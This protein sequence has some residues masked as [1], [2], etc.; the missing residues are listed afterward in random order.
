MAASD[1]ID[2]LVVGH[3]T[4]DLVEEG[5]RCGGA[6]LYAS[7]TAD[8][9]GLRAAILTRAASDEDLRDVPT[10][11]TVYRL[12]SRATTEFRNIYEGP[13]RTQQMTAKGA[14]IGP[15]DVPAKVT[16]SRTVL[17]G[18]VIGEIDPVVRSRFSGRVAV[19]AQ[20]WLRT[21]TG[22]NV[23]Y[24]PWRAD[25]ALRGTEAVFA[26]TEDAPASE[27]PALVFRWRGAVPIV[28]VTEGP[29]GGTLYLTDSETAIPR[30]PAREVDPTG[31]GD[32]FAAAFLAR[33]V[34][35]SDPY[36]AAEF[37]AAAAACS[38]EGTGIS[39]IPD[40]DMIAARRRE[41]AVG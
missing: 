21:A 37:A 35:T 12:P 34:E 36:E 24:A 5:W 6:A 1:T 39:A 38:V 7:A 17:L 28:I 31:A 10:S 26:S 18:P 41:G 23:R 33:Y 8:K 14:D 9:L 19:G 4:R 30:F 15:E 27:M 29:R 13:H 20:G 11:V 32:V 40:R 3:I 2:F 25:K 22:R 16:G